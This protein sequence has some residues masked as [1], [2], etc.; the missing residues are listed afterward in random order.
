VECEA[1]GSLLVLGLQI[2]YRGPRGL[3]EAPLS[4]LVDGAGRTH[5]PKSLVWKSGSKQLAQ[6]LA[7]GGIANLQAETRGALQL[8]FELRATSGELK[9]EFGDIA[10]FA[11]TRKASALACE[12]L[13]KPGEIRAPRV[14]RAARVEG[15][16]ADLRVYRAAYPCLSASGAPATTEAQHPP[17]LPRQLLV[18][19]RGYLPN[20]RE[21]ALPMGRAPAQSY[22]YVGVDEVKAVEQ[23]ARRTAAADFPQYGSAKHFAFDWGVQRSASDNELYSFGLYELRVC[24]K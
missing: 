7:A 3:V 20:V 16:K 24:P 4:Q 15:T 21:I 13:L 6:W 18:F 2:D 23:A 19:G 8:K 9:L 11:L 10:A 12:R 1:A 5:A 22:A 17:Y 14:A